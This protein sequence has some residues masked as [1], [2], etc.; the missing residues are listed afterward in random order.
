M[1]SISKEF[2]DIIKDS[3]KKGTSPY[4]TAAEVL[5][6]DGKTAWVRIPG[7]VDETPAKLSIDAKKGDTV[8]IRVADGVAFLVGNNSAPPT[9]DTAAREAAKAASRAIE[10]AEVAN[11]SAKE[12][13]ADAATARSAAESAS[14]SAAQAIEDAATAQGA[15]EAAQEDATAAG[16]AAESAQADATA[17]GLAADAAQADATAAAEAASVADGKAVAAGQSAAAA[18]AQAS[19]AQTSANTANTY[20]NAALDQLGMV[21]DVMGVLQWASEHGTFTLTQ[22]SE[23]Q[24]GKVYFTYDSQTGDYEPVVNPQESALSTYY[25]LTVDEAMQSYIMAHLAVTSRGLWVL[26]SGKASGTTPASGESQD[27]SDA[28]Q[29][30]DYKVLLSNDG[31][32]VYDDD[33]VLV[34]TFGE[35][36]T[37]SSLRQQY[38]GNQNTYIAFNPANGGSITIGGGSRVVIGTNKT[39]DQVLTDLDVSVEQTA[40]GADITIN[41]DTVSI[42]NGQDGDTGDTGP[43]AVVTVYPTTIDWVAGTATL[44]VTLRVDGVITTPSTYKWT[45]GAEATSLGTSSTLAVTDLYA[46]YNC[47]VTTQTGTQ[48]GSIDLS[49]GKGAYDES[50]VYAQEGLGSKVDLAPNSAS[51]SMLDNFEAIKSQINLIASQINFG[52]SSTVEEQL[53][54]YNANVSIDTEHSIVR[55]GNAQS[56]HVSITPTE[57][58]FWQGSEETDDNKIAWVS[59]NQLHINQTVVLQQMDLGLPVMDSGLGQWSW[60]VHA[61]GQSP[62]R[63][64]LN[65]KWIG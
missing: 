6:V 62:S 3:E 15:A 26:P 13:V 7:G 59:G 44:A 25:E 38:I 54:I 57:L 2:I 10:S 43:E 31:M 46:V 53:S 55:I 5:R 21:Q 60:K 48:T 35:S 36:I 32:Y 47:T 14:E 65:L 58:G 28:R 17:A 29:G 1:S 34:S 4:D 8:Q 22:D 39:L 12:A 27:D 20:A 52:A 18:A 51:S 40:T 45:K 56:T 63:N 42:E 64:N 23:I 9:D 19:A 50:I 30:D 49:G 41:G 11:A 37:F 24:P 33:G 61:N 16:L